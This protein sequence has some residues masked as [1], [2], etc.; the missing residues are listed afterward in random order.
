MED[1]WVCVQ[2]RVDKSN[3][4]LVGGK[5]L[6]IN[7]VE[8]RSKGRSGSRGTTNWSSHVSIWHR[9][10]THE[11]SDQVS[12]VKSNEIVSAVKGTRK[13]RHTEGWGYIVEDNDVITNSADIGVSS[14]CA[15]EDAAVCANVFIIGGGVRR[16]WRRT[17][18]KVFIHSGTL[19][20][21]H[22]VDV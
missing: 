13:M 6:F 3:C 2:S 20:A 16:V 4:G 11:L 15:V 19:V 10:Y 5:S 18:G 12:G 9:K 1:L 22:G 8:N 7:E 14:A 21:W 17:V